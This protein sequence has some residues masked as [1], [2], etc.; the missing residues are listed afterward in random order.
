MP[1]QARNLQTAC[2]DSETGA[3]HGE[4]T[5]ARQGPEMGLLCSLGRKPAKEVNKR[6]RPEG[7]TEKR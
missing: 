6:K 5:R 3:A 2:A 1:A 7:E 4:G